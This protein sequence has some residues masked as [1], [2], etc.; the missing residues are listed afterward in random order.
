MFYS[1]KDK[2]R[3]ISILRDR[4]GNTLLHKEEKEDFSYVPLAQYHSRIKKNGST[5]RANVTLHTTL[6]PSAKWLFIS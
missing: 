3:K 2:Y 5:D 6:L 4:G 1:P